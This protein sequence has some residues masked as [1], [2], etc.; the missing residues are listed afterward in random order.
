MG[1]FDI[2]VSFEKLSPYIQH[3]LQYTKRNASNKE[4]NDLSIPIRCCERRLTK[5]G[6]NTPVPVPYIPK[7]AH[8]IEGPLTA[9]QSILAVSPPEQTSQPHASPPYEAVQSA[10]LKFRTTECRPLKH[11]SFKNF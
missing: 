2:F 6:N 5:S 9:E 7:L 8:G 3:R 10:N 1:S 4:L 11:K